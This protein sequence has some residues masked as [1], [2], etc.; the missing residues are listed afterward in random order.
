MRRRQQVGHVIDG[1]HAVER[2][3]KAKTELLQLSLSLP[4]FLCGSRSAECVNINFHFRERCLF[5]L[6]R[7]YSWALNGRLEE[8]HTFADFFYF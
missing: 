3:Q 5:A 8:L 2:E 6:L 7:V 1:L 4:L